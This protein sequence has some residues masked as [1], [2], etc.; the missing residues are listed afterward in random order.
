MIEEHKPLDHVNALISYVSDVQ[1]LQPHDGE[2]NEFPD[3]T[4]ASFH[5]HVGNIKQFVSD[6]QISFN[7][8]EQFL[9]QKSAINEVQAALEDL[10]LFP[11]FAPLVV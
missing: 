8:A 5:N 10:F 4:I 11:F 7:A 3:R 9:S 2:Y 6:D 1:Q